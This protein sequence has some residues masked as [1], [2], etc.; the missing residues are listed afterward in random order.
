MK[1]HADRETL[2]RARERVA[3]VEPRL[4]SMLWGMLRDSSIRADDL[5]VAMAMDEA[6]LS[7]MTASPDMVRFRVAAIIAACSLDRSAARPFL[8]VLTAEA[9]YQITPFSVV[10]EDAPSDE[11][12]LREVTEHGLAAAESQSEELGAILD[13][14]VSGAELTRLES[15]WA[16]EDEERESKRGAIR[17]RCRDRSN[18]LSRPHMFKGV[19]R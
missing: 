18:F 10:Y 19:A 17:A 15:R 4:S 16:R 6:D 7:K 1:P 11:T 8:E 2:K 9:G 12:V 3:V 13:G 14:L 5:A